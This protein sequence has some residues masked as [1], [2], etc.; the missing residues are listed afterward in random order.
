MR[1]DW[2]GRAELSQTQ[3]L[4]QTLQQALH[5]IALPAPELAETL[6]AAAADNP[7]LALRG[8]AAD[9]GG[10]PLTDAA[11]ANG[12]GLLEHVLS[13]L[14]RLF[15]DPADRR[16]ALALAEALDARGWL[17]EPPETIARARAI[18][19]DRLEAVRRR[20]Q[21]MDPPG[22]FAR[23]LADCL[24]AQLRAEGAFSPLMARLLDHLD[25]VA[26]GCR[27]RLAR[28]CGTDAATL[29]AALA[30]LRRLDP[31]PGHRFGWT[32]PPPLRLPDLL[33]ARGPAGWQVAS[34][35]DALPRL[36]LDRALWARLGA[37][38]RTGLRP[39][40]DGARRMVTA[41]GLRQR[42]LLAVGRCIVAHQSRALDEGDTAL[43]A[44]TRREIAGTLGMHESTVGRIARHA[45]FGI[46]GRT[47]P[48]RHFL[49]RPCA[50]DAAGQ[51]VS[52][53]T[54]AALIRGWQADP[55][56]GRLDDAR[57]AALLA[58]QGI[59]LPR[60]TISRHR[61]LATATR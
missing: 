55:A 33:L 17:A 47:V 16:I 60:R 28:L 3:G 7:F 50:T 10:S 38:D 14:P 54:V 27:A 2:Q 48:F 31:H 45:G 39:T 8:R 13:R 51:P 19:L 61:A 49:G 43:R 44:L 25:L 34:N 15:P 42:A 30:D 12:P 52:R 6:A 59:H 36:G 21:T 26:G 5:L 23:D 24:A 40:W 20:L 11:V 18:P 56:A 53:Y 46:A 29:A 58:Q 32:P 1:L 37:A 9:G 4:G 57:I 22:L 41:L 35:P